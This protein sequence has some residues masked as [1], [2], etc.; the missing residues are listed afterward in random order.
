MDC[1]GIRRGNVD[2]ENRRIHCRI[3]RPDSVG[4]NLRS[5]H[6]QFAS[7]T[8]RECGCH[9]RG[10]ELYMGD[11]QPDSRQERVN[12]SRSIGGFSMQRLWPHGHPD[13]LRVNLERIHYIDG[14]GKRRIGGGCIWHGRYAHRLHNMDGSRWSL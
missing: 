1:A 3:R 2:I 4:H 8:F 7:D 6:D 14:I 10:H 13:L 11:E 5:I 9:G 12:H